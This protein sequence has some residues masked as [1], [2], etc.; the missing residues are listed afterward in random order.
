VKLE[1]VKNGKTLPCVNSTTPYEV[2]LETDE[3]TLRFC[4]GER[5]LVMCGERT[6][7]SQDH[8]HAEVFVPGKHQHDG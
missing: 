1:A 2:L 7:G 6:V 4:F 8:A 5:S 3:G